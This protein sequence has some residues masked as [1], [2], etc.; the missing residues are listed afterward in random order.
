MFE[1]YETE[2]RPILHKLLISFDFFFVVKIFFFFPFEII[3]KSSL[4][5]FEE[6]SE[7]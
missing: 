4:K 6:I 5:W 2:F 7:N 3:R 1:S